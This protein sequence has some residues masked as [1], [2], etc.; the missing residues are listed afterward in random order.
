M[1]ETTLIDQAVVAEPIVTPTVYYPNSIKSQHQPS[2]IFRFNNGEI[3][4]RK[5]LYQ[6]LGSEQ[7]RFVLFVEYKGELYITRTDDRHA[8]WVNICKKNDLFTSAMI[9]H[10]TFVRD[11]MR[12]MGLGPG[13]DY[14]VDVAPHT[15]M[16]NEIN[17]DPA[18]Y[19][20][21]LYR[22]CLDKKLNR[23]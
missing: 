22:I 21:P 9:C 8:F 1:S 15:V 11:L 12:R 14:S 6:L 18:K 20:Y 19:P 2:A 7:V 3:G 4:I 23:Q 10:K 13:D 16:A 17:A 5:G